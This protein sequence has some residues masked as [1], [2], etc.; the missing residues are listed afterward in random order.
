MKKLFLFLVGITM[1]L[2][3]DAQMYHDN[4]HGTNYNDAWIS[5]NTLASPNPDRG[6]GHWIM[7][8]LRHPYDL[9]QFTFWNLNDAERLE[10]GV[11]NIIIDVSNNGNDWSEVGN[12]T[13]PRSDGS[14]F[15]KG[16]NAIDLNGMTARY[17]LLTATSNYGGNCYGLSE[18]KFGVSEASLP[19]TLVDINAE[20]IDKGVAINWTVTSEYN[21]ESYTCQYSIDGLSW[22]DIGSIAGENKAEENKYRYVHNEAPFANTY[23]RIVQKDY[24][25]SLTYFP[26]VKADCSDELKTFSVFPNPVASTAVIT[27]SDINSEQKRFRI[28]DA[29]GRNIR[30]GQVSG[31]EVKLELSDLSPGTYFITIGEGNVQYREK[32]IKL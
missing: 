18:V 29:M 12:Y 31:T 11:Q 13:I 6:D 17:V 8:D 5:C 23:Y 32:I 20:C 14:A 3:M 10:D 22:T 16:V 2:S 26:V 30:S 19:V 1:Y 27:F 28:T 21:N 15:Y 25:G 24:D 9:F 7:Y 4:R